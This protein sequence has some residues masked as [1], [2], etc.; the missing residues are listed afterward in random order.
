[1]DFSLVKH[2]HIITATLFLLFLLFKSTLVLLNR[3]D[4]LKK[5]KKYILVPDILIQTGFLVSGLTLIFMGS[6][7]V[8]SQPAWFHIKMVAVVVGVILAI[9]AFKKNSKVLVVVSLLVFVM[10]YGYTEM[11]ASKQ[12]KGL[13]SENIQTSDT[14]TGKLIYSQY[15]NSCH[16][17]NGKKGLSGAKDLS[18]SKLSAEESLI[19]ISEGRN[20]MM[21]YQNQLSKEQMV[22]VNN[23]IQ[24]FK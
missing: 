6:S 2:I 21:A 1:M 3:S 14:L 15:C 7:L 18:L 9:I 4:T 13:S 20:S 17:D 10:I 8:N 23:Y 5:A 19:V 16:G 11:V 22:L 24:D 12:K